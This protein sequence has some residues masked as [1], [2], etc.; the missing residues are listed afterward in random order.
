MRVL[1]VALLLAGCGA[2]T[3]DR[4]GTVIADDGRLPRTV[5]TFWT[6]TID[7]RRIPCV[8]AAGENKGGLS[9]DWSSR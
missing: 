5:G 9:C 7:G 6:T 2:P 3:T 4:T 8:W 1:L